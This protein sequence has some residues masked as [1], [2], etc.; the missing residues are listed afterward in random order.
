MV[1][2]SAELARRSLALQEHSLRV[3]SQL[4]PQVFSSFQPSTQGSIADDFA[5]H[6]PTGA[7]SHSANG[8]ISLH[9]FGASA[10]WSSAFSQVRHFSG[11]A[12]TP[13]A[14]QEYAYATTENSDTFEDDSIADRTRIGGHPVDGRGGRDWAGATFAE[15]P[16]RFGV[17]SPTAGNG[18]GWTRQDDASSTPPSSI[19]S[20]EYFAKARQESHSFASSSG[21]E[22]PDDRAEQRRMSL[23]AEARRGKVHWVEI[24]DHDGL[25]A[26]D[27]YGT[28]V[29]PRL[30]KF[31]QTSREELEAYRLRELAER[32]GAG[33][34]GAPFLAEY[35][36]P[37]KFQVA[38]VA[39]EGEK[40]TSPWRPET[41][42]AKGGVKPKNMAPSP[43][44]RT[45][46]SV[47]SY[48]EKLLAMGQYEEV[49][50]EFTTYKRWCQAEYE[51]ISDRVTGKM[52]T[53][54]LLA[55]LH[56]KVS[57]NQGLSV[58]P[59][60]YR[61]PNLVLDSV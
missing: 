45:V 6:G 51:Q 4:L 17:Q 26:K 9:G 31:L 56:S 16:K 39:E 10:A 44:F 60:C 47:E 14:C 25:K 22:T 11:L 32:R 59:Q 33:V 35:R 21:D 37:D 1:G 7:A 61:D 12:A 49:P 27:C 48:L 29:D 54:V 28:Q 23:K 40:F 58:H 15:R 2:P 55:F 42:A 52:Y 38:A 18:V 20:E 5:A 41:P 57:L 3:L 46:S 19:T 8:G 50:K 53:S 43:K 34:N 30:D 36:W 13:L 24:D